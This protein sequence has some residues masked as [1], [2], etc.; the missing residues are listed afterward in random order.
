M[1]LN[2]HRVEGAAQR[3]SRDTLNDSRSDPC[4]APSSER[5]LGFGTPPTTRPTRPSAD[6]RYTRSRADDT[7]RCLRPSRPCRT[8]FSVDAEEL[9]ALLRDSS[10]SRP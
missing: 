1:R 3:E 10:P 2:L 9:L 7:D 6:E 4:L 8:C 5:I